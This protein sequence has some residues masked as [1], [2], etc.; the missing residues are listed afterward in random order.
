M[1][2]WLAEGVPDADLTPCADCGG[3]GQASV[4]SKYLQGKEGSVICPA[5]YGWGSLTRFTD[6]ELSPCVHCY[7]TGYRYLP[8]SVWFKWLRPLAPLSRKER[9]PACNGL[10]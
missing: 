5:C 1:L 8:V 7:G 9:C 2:G 4:W 10:G 3:T 6:P